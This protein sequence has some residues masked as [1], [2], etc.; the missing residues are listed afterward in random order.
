MDLTLHCN[1]LYTGHNI[2]TDTA[3]I[4][5]PSAADRVTDVYWIQDGKMKV[6]DY[7]LFHLFLHLCGGLGKAPIRSKTCY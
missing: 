6:K 1:F 5:D 7:L 4:A 2:T 3:I